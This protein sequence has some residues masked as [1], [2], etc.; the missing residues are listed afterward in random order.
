MPKREDRHGQPFEAKALGT[1]SKRNSYIAIFVVVLLTVAVGFGFRIIRNEGTGGHG[2]EQTVGDNAETKVATI[3]ETED[4]ILRTTTELPKLARGVLN[5]QLPDVQA[6]E[7]FAEKVKVLGLESI[8]EPISEF[9]VPELDVLSQNWP[10]ANSARSGSPGEIRLWKPLFARLAFFE[11][12]KFYFVRASFANENRN[13]ITADVNFDGVARTPDG[14]LVHIQAKQQVDWKKPEGSGQDAWQIVSWKQKSLVTTHRDQ[15]LF[16]DVVNQVI[17]EQLRQQ[18]QGSAHEQILLELAASP[19]PVP[20]HQYFSTHASSR[21]P[22]VS[23]VDIDRDG[24]DDIYVMARW[25]RNLMFRN[26]GDGT[27]EEIASRVGLDI[28]DHCASAMFADFDND[29][30]TDLFLGRTLQR[31]MYLVNENGHFVDRSSSH[32]LTELPYLVFSISAA[33][34]NGDGLMDVYFSTYGPQNNLKP[35]ART[36][37]WLDDFLAPEQVEELHQLRTNHHLLN[38]AG[39]PNVLMVNRG[40]GKFDLAA[41]SKQVGAW[42][43]TTQGT[44]SDFDDDGDLDL[45][46]SNDYSVN[47]MFRNDGAQ[48]FVDVTKPMQTADV[49]FGMGVSWGDYDL[50]GR[51]DLYVSNMFSKAGQRITSQIDSL[52]PRF[53]QTAR[54]NS[55]FRNIDGSFKKVSGLAPPALQVEKAGWSWSGQ[56]V[57]I[58][59]DGYLDIHALSGYYTAPK[60]IAFAAD[61]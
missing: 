1:G 3:V 10:V 57:D 14:Q 50:D 49:G 54:G 56:F 16:Q 9:S 55:L 40:G 37:R 45:Y 22:S 38:R 17:P 4:W 25:G 5:M 47:T 24:F 39:P 59:N 13:E 26:R 44:W 30:D 7:L 61:Y 6:T 41:E 42:R 21:H 29:G 53:A 43:Q 20:P 48:G 23:V 8:E 52:D 15:T 51:Q 60:Q 19:K 11:R 12:A 46:L 58:N 36:K 33:D 27:F 2:T 18:V 28:E 31:S 32:I 34:Y 35:N